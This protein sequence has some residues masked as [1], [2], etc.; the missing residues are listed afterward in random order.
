MSE[1]C[2]NCCGRKSVWVPLQP[3]V[4][5]ELVACTR[6]NGTGEEAEPQIEAD[7]VPD[8]L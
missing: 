6:C 2:Y 7:W 1:P 8:G 4:G 3:V 5:G